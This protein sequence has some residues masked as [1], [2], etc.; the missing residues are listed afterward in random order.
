MTV[1][2]MPG[3][4]EFGLCLNGMID[5]RKVAFTG[6]NLF[7]DAGDPAQ[8]CHEAVVAHNSSIFEEGYIYAG[9]YLKRLQ[10]DLIV[11]GHSFVMDHPAAM[12][13]RY[14]A[15]AYEMRD[16][17]KELVAADDYRYGYDP[18]WVRAEPCRQTI[19][20]GQSA[21]I[22]LSARNFLSRAQNDRIEFHAPPGLAVEPGGCTGLVPAASRRSWKIRVQAAPEAAPGVHLIA[23]DITRD[24][25]RLGEMFDFTVQVD[26]K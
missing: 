22:T 18:F 21:E 6:D 8:T 5:G 25:K 26:P 10:P 11:G 16:A 17:F 15:W 14:R 3:Q 19:K 12:I 2:W 9:E 1:D 23:L 4:T 24:G 13:E 7:G 20:P